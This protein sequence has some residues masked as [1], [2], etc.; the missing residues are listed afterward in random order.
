[1]SL[2]LDPRRTA[3]VLIDLQK[4]IL[5]MPGLAPHAPEQVLARGIALARR[6]LEAGGTV[7]L[8]QVGFAPDG[9]DRLRQPVEAPM[10]AGPLPADWSDLAPELAALPAQLVVKKRGW[11]AFHGTEL[12]LQLRR[13]GIDTI[14]LG[15]IATNLGVEQTVREGWQHNYAMVVAEDAC[16]AP[17]AAMHAFAFENILPRIARIRGTEQV[18]AA[19]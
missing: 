16:T 13:R 3:L 10:P 11:G 1:M 18:L 19:L 5:S 12:D 7:V 2:I 4:G 8:V 17:D 6:M 9:A 14:V 15:G